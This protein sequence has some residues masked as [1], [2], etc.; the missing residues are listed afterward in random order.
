[1][2]QTGLSEINRQTRVIFVK[3][4]YEILDVYVIVVIEMTPPPINKKKNYL[5]V[6][7]KIR[8][9]NRMLVTVMKIVI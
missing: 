2:P 5:N 8:G 3:E 1:M 9:V 7:K 6:S 4:F